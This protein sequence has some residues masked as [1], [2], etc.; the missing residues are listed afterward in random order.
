MKKLSMIFISLIIFSNFFAQ[1]FYKNGINEITYK[2]KY[3][4]YTNTSKLK[5]ISHSPLKVSWKS[6]NDSTIV[7]L[8]ENLNTKKM[9]YISKN[10]NLELVKK[11]RIIYLEGTYEGEKIKKQL[12]IDGDHWYQLFV[13]SFT[14]FV[15][16]DDKSRNYWVFNPFDI[17]M[18]E[19]KVKK[20]EKDFITINGKKI[21]SYYLNTRLTGLMS[22]F[23]KGEYWYN[24]KNGMYLKYDGLNIYPEIQNVVITAENWR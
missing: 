10:I 19:M 3:N 17:S 18:N 23:W 4:N 16:S 6:K 7:E 21:E 13:F 14:D 5:I 11:E 22:I 9:T 2:E 15:F 12:I 8:D 24:S 1:E 20:I